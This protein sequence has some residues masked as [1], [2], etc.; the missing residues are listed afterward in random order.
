M[1]TPNTTAAD[2]RPNCSRGT[3]R[4]TATSKFGALNRPGAYGMRARPLAAVQ[5]VP[6][7]RE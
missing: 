6:M 1:S 7:L 5:P 2:E 4:D 3:C